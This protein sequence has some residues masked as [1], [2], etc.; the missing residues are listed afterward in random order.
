HV[1]TIDTSNTPPPP[2]VPAQTPEQAPDGV[3][4]MR[5]LTVDQRKAVNQLRAR[6]GFPLGELERPAPPQPRQ[7]SGAG[8][9]SPE[10]VKWLLRY[11]PRQFVERYGVQRV[12]PIEVTIPSRV[13]PET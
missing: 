11:H 2:S 4:G 1:S 9:K 13:D 5:G 7:N 8:D 6:E 10:F 3:D 12:G